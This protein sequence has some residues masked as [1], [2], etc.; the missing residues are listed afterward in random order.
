LSENNDDPPSDSGGSYIYFPDNKELNKA[1]KQCIEFWRREKRLSNSEAAVVVKKE[2]LDKL[3]NGNEKAA[4]VICQSVLK[5]SWYNFYALNK[6][7]Q[8]QLEKE[9]GRPTFY[10]GMSEEEFESFALSN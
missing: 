2:Y 1:F 7:Q 5:N 8:E 10:N 4:L 3:S 9:R 6:Q